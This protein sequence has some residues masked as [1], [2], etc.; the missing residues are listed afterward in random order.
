MERLF[1]YEFIYLVPLT[2]SAIVSLRAFT[3]RWPL[4]FKVFSTFLVL[5]LLIEVS[6]IAWK[7]VLAPKWQYS[8]SNMWIYNGFVVVR[9]LYIAIF[10]HMALQY[11]RL[12]IVLVGSSFALAL[13]ALLNYFFVQGPHNVNTFTIIP[14]NTLIILVVLI[15]FHQALN[16][17]RVIKLGTSSEIWISLGTFLYYSGTLPFFIFFNYLIEVNSPLLR[18]YLYINDLLNVTMYTVYSIAFLC[19]P[20][21]LK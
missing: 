12:K 17:D 4:H 2:I 10:Y 9:Y 18:S 5:T 11:T 14:A 6:A 15:F 19:K 7:W 1:S 13:Y 20:Q 3:L 8:P 21:F 16:E